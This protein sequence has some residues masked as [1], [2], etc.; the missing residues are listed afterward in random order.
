MFYMGRDKDIY[1]DEVK[2]AMK[3]NSIVIIK[4]PRRNEGGFIE[5]I[6]KN[7][8]CSTN[9]DPIIQTLPGMGVKSYINFLLVWNNENEAIKKKIEECIPINSTSTAYY[10][11]LVLNSNI[12]ILTTPTCEIINDPS[13]YEIIDVGQSLKE[14]K[15][16]IFVDDLSNENLRK[17]KTLNF[18]E[19]LTNELIIPKS[20][21]GMSVNTENTIFFSPEDVVFFE[22]VNSIIYAQLNEDRVRIKTTLENL[23][24]ELLGSFFRTHRCYLANLNYA[25]ELT[26]VSKSSYEISIGNYNIPL[27]KY[28]LKAFKESIHQKNR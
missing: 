9:V 5:Y 16:I 3:N 6:L 7:Y 22:S 27:S 26:Q 12:V 2:H 21:N 25:I 8:D 13:F 11:N 4:P 28:R 20:L 1:L 14:K 23:E 17:Y 10:L 15:Y 24:K 18:S 19:P